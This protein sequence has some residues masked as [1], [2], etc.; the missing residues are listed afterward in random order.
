MVIASG[1]GLLNPRRRAAP[2]ST[3]AAVSISART[4]VVLV[5]A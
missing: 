2:K 3:G 1:S 4:R 5:R